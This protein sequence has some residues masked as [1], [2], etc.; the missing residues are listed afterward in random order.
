[1]QSW[2]SMV[3]VPR[4]WGGDISEEYMVA[5]WSPRLQ[6]IP[7]NMRPTSSIDFRTAP[8]KIAEPAEGHPV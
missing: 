3:S 2:N 5:D 6:A 7:Q 8:A 4:R 1:M